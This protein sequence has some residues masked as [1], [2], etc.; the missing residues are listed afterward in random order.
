MQGDYARALEEGHHATDP[1]EARVLG[2]M[3]RDRD[4]ID[5]ARREEQRFAAAPLV[6]CFVTGLRAALEGRTDSARAALAQ[7]LDSGFSDGEGLFYAAGIYARMRML[8]E[9][10]R[11]LA[12]AVDAGFA[13]FQAYERDP[14]LEPLRAGGGMAALLERVAARRQSVLAAFEAAR[15]PALLGVATP[16][17]GTGLP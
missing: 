4:A 6:H 10:S 11:L 3:G 5:A 9:A 13:C 12:S 1:L 15:G 17:S 8:D 14:Y 2:A 7:L 16:A